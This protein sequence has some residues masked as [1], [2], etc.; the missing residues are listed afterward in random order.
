ML[1][2]RFFEMGQRQFSRLPACNIRRLRQ[3]SNCRTNDALGLAESLPDAIRRGIGESALEIPEGPEFIVAADR[4]FQKRPQAVRGQEQAFDLVG[5]PKAE[6][7]T[8]ASR[9]ISIAAIDTCRANRFLKLVFLVVATQKTVPDE[10][11]HPFAMRT[12][13]RFQRGEKL[14]DFLLGAADSSTHDSLP[15][16]NNQ[17]THCTAFAHGKKLVPIVEKMGRGS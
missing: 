12:S 5:R 16:R 6:G 7:S 15:A 2:E 9:S 14:L 4:L 8:A 1:P 11:P 3:G 10:V 17:T 13:R